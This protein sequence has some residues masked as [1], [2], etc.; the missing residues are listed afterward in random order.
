M[1]KDNKGRSF[2]FRDRRTHK[3]SPKPKSDDLAADNRKTAFLYIRVST[4]EQADRGFSQRDQDQRLHDYCQRNNIKVVRVIYEDYSAKTFKKRP[5]WMKMLTELKKTNG[6]LCDLIL[7]TKWDRFSRNTANAYQMIDVLQGL[8]VEPNAID[9]HLDL[10][11]P[12][13]RIMLAVY[14]A[15]AEADNLRRGL[16]VAVGMRRGKVE[17]RWM[18]RAPAAY[19]NKIREDK[20]KYIDIVE[21]EATHLK[22]AFETL[23]EGTFKTEVVWRMARSRGL[24]MKKNT[25]WDCVQNPMYCGKVVVPAD[26]H[27]EM[28]LADGK[29]TPIV[30]EKIFWEVQDVLSGRR[31]VQVIRAEIPIELILRGHLI[32]PHCGK[33]LSGSASKGRYEYYHYYHCRWPCRARIPAKPLNKD[34]EDELK[35]Y[36]P[37][38]G[39][40]KVFK[41]IICDVNVDEQQ[42]FDAE[43]K[44]LIADISEQNN[45]LTRL[46]ALLLSDDIDIADY[47]AMKLQAEEK[48]S[49][50]EVELKDLKQKQSVD[51]DL[52]ALVDEVLFRL[53][54]LIKLYKKGT[55]EEKTYIIGSVYPEKMRIS[56]N[57]VRTGEVNLAMQLIYQI[58][59]GLRKKKTGVRS[60][61]RT[62]SGSV[63]SAGV[64][65]ARFPTGV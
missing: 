29:H 49:R 48:V 47:K 61:N 22:W 40:E 23:A 52:C 13:S 41:E 16:N 2:G 8:Y 35:S 9:Q 53:K 57:L 26:E 24:K 64:E 33:Q 38:P 63:P 45:T 39:M 11:I 56:E 37:I 20:T 3:L 32:C 17:G 58:N 34:F 42:N 59:K 54:N 51:D 27:N 21:P 36:V 6:K 30:S 55:I 25:F 12:E 50:L 18:G 44:Q 19:V 31:K 10:K 15:Q 14:I 1:I 46:R 43:R 28:Y 65:P 62:N 4:D 60:K 5:E 7:F